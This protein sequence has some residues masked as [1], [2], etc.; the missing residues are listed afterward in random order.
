M[1]ISVVYV[2]FMGSG[3]W[4]VDLGTYYWML[5]YLLFPFHRT[6]CIQI[7]THYIVSTPIDSLDYL[8]IPIESG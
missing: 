4:G 8:G 2:P 7:L 6:N 5:A 1:G 3:Q